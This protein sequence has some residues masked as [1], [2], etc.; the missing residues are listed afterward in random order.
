MEIEMQSLVEYVENVLD[1][2]KGFKLKAKY[3]REFFEVDA[4]CS[5]LI[6]SPF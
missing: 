4:E 1:H 6:P 2:P 5:R 3:A